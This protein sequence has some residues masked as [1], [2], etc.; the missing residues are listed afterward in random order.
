MIPVSLS[1]DRPRTR[2]RE[3]A[4]Q[5]GRPGSPSQ[6]NATPSPLNFRFRRPNAASLSESLLKLA[7]SEPPRRRDSEA[8]LGF[9][10]ASGLQL[11]AR[12]ARI[13]TRT[14]GSG[15]RQPEY[16]TWPMSG[17]TVVTVKVRLTRGG[18]P[19]PYRAR[20][21]SESETHTELFS[22]PCSTIS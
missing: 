2:R 13:P 7:A 16:M 3:A 22:N 5:T 10:K 21:S 19:A 17:G 18:S 20:P 11:V 15:C 12:D 1:L 4:N 8:R 14:A 9:S 6:L